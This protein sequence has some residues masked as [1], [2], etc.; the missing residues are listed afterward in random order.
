MMTSVSIIIA[1][2]N[3]TTIIITIAGCHIRGEM[4]R[5]DDVEVWSS[6]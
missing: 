4:Q 3:S 6:H 5:D 1:T 2:I